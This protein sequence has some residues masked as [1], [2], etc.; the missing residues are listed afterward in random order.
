M[1]LIG[2]GKQD[3]L[4]A[5]NISKMN[6]RD[7]Y[8]GSSLGLLW[9]VFNPLLLL[10]MYTFIFGFIFKSKAPG[11][12]TTF[13]YAIWLISG[14]VPYL[15]ISEALLSTAGSVVSGS[16]MIKNVVFKSEVLPYAATLSSAVPFAVGMFFLFVLLFADGNY[17]TWHIIYLI[18]MVFLQLAFLGGLGLFLSS[19]TVFI[20]DIMQVLTTLTLFIMFFTPIFYTREMMPFIVQK[21]TVLNPFYHMTNPYRQILLDHQSPEIF[22]LIYLFFWVFVLNVVGLRFF[23]KL[24]GY[25]EIKL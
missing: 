24:K 17:P 14:L 7:R 9:A 10:G 21:L 6:V 12:D 15:V 11:A 1:N 25:F 23:R 18:P 13:S 20:R 3:L 5:I 8:L 4:L 2:L 19:L 22:S 16:S